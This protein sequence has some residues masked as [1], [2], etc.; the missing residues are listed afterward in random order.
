MNLVLTSKSDR[1]K[2]NVLKVKIF[3]QNVHMK[4][5]ETNG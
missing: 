4:Y 2:K 5:S 3:L 1:N